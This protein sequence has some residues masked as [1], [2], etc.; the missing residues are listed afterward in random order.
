LRDYLGPLDPVVD[1]IARTP[2]ATASTAAMGF[3]PD[4]LSAGLPNGDDSLAAL[5]ASIADGLHAALD[6]DLI[7]LLVQGWSKAGPL[8]PFRD[9]ARYPPSTIA[10]MTLT[11]HAVDLRIDPELT[12]TAGGMRMFKLKLAIALTATVPGATLVVRA[13]AIQAVEPGPVGLEGQVMWGSTILPL[14][15]QRREIDCQGSFRIDPPRR[16]AS[17][18]AVDDGD[19]T[20]PQ[21]LGPS[22]I[23]RA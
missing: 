18:F 21:A 23:Q 4:S 1:A 15:L 10:R 8:R 14:P 16:I 11:P 12:L 6:L 3:V 2:V 9:E 20:L 19:D 5:R 13:G 22:A 17:L 7:A